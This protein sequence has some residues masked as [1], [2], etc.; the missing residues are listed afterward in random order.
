MN[1]RSFLKTLTGLAV[2]IA[3][4]ADVI[5]RQMPELWT[6]SAIRWRK[7][8]DIAWNSWLFSGDVFIGRKIGETTTRITIENPENYFVELRSATEELREQDKEAA[9]MVLMAKINQRLAELN[10]A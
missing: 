10:N 6:A 3:I 7:A 5:A 2:S 1:R 8:Y 4:P 9:V